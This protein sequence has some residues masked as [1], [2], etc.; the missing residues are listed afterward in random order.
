[1]D[2]FVR[3]IDRVETGG[4]A[5]G[6]GVQLL[7]QVQ[8]AAVRGVSAGS[9]DAAAGERAQQAQ[10]ETGGQ[11]GHYAAGGSG[12][13]PAYDRD[14]RAHQGGAFGEQD[15]HGPAEASGDAADEDRG[16]Q[17]GGGGLVLGGG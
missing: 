4:Q 12:L 14:P 3:E 7:D 5:A 11:P 2:C 13:V 15:E 10:P 17:V 9:G 6:E 8:G 1:V 16:G